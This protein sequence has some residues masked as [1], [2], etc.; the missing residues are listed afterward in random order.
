[1]ENREKEAEAFFRGCLD[2]SIYRF[3]AC[4]EKCAS[5]TSTQKIISEFLSEIN[6]HTIIY[7]SD[8]LVEMEWMREKLG[9]LPKEKYFFMTIEE[10]YCSRYKGDGLIL[11]DLHFTGRDELLY[12]LDTDA[13]R[14]L[15]LY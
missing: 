6:H 7:C 10:L 12:P 15:I 13:S 3:C 4:I 2:N 8:S 9:N 14:F 1:M 11:V 5:Y